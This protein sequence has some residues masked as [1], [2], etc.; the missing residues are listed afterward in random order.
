[1]VNVAPLMGKY[2]TFTTSGK[3]KHSQRFFTID[4]T[5]GEETVNGHDINVKIGNLRFDGSNDLGAVVTARAVRSTRGT[6][7]WNCSAM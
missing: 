4:N 3:E 5:I 1:M 7:I 6:R 2:T